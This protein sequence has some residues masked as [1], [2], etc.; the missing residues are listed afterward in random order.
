M[1]RVL[2]GKCSWISGHSGA[3]FYV[4]RDNCTLE[5]MYKFNPDDKKPCTEKAR[6]AVR[7]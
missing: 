7:Y 6:I 1:K 5:T 4:W 3:F 2:V